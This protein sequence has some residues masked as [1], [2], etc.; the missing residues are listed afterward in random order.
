MRNETFRR[1]RHPHPA[2]YRQ[3]TSPLHSSLTKKVELALEALCIMPLSL[4]LNS[5][6][7]CRPIGLGDRKWSKDKGGEDTKEQRLHELC[8]LLMIA[9]RSPSFSFC[10]QVRL[11]NPI[12]SVVLGVSIGLCILL[13]RDLLDNFLRKYLAFVYK[14]GTDQDTIEQLIHR[15]EHKKMNTDQKV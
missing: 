15:I 5:G 10:L 3:A 7:P 1:H 11:L 14:V 8:S 12:R 6:S 2:A 13:F 4:T 9:R